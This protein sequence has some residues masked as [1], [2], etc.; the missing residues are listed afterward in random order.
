MGQ[1]AGM[2]KVITRLIPPPNQPP[3][4]P[5]RAP[6]S[7]LRGLRGR[8]GKEICGTGAARKGEGISQDTTFLGNEVFHPVEKAARAAAETLIIFPR[9]Q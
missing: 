7:E 2:H 3:A 5:V 6:N 8:R 9:I 4:P 1:G